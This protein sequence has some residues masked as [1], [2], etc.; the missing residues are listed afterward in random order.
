VLGKDVVSRVGLF[1]SGGAY[2]DGSWEEV[3][4]R[5]KV[6]H[7][8]ARHTPGILGV[9]CS[10]IVGAVRWILHT[11]AGARRLDAWL[12]KQREGS[13]EEPTMTPEKEREHII[14]I[15]LEGFAQGPAATVQEALLLSTHW[16]FDLEDVA[17]D[18]VLMWH[19][20]EDVNAP[21]G[22]IRDLARRV[23]GSQLTEFKGDTHF[24]MGR[25]LDR[26]LGELVP[27]SVR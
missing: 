1:A 18:P 4:T 3:P 8:A 15:M 19:G 25:H 27:E 16:G 5:S 22:W 7:Y 17:Y 13:E 23:R 11:D 9:A 26:V 10:S 14:R 24:T 12:A 6:A 2:D 20:T 21:I